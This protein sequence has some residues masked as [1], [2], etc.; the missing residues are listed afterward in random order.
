[1]DC[2]RPFGCYGGLFKMHNAQTDSHTHTVKTGFIKGF[3]SQ[4]KYTL[5]N[6]YLIRDKSSSVCFVLICLIY[7]YYLNERVPEGLRQLKYP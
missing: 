5:V 6:T 2:S 7:Y 3:M 1:M 4:A